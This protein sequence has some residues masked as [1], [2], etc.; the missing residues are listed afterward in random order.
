[1]KKLFI[2]I[3]ALLA[4]GGCASKYAVTFDSY[5][6][7]A[8]LLCNGTNWGYTPVTLYYDKA[9]KKQ[10]SLSLGSCSANWTSGA[11]K[12]YGVVPVSQYPD[13]VRQTLQRPNEPNAHIDHSFALQ[14]QQNK[15][16]N[17][18]LQ[19]QSAMQAEQQRVKNE[20]QQED[21]TQ[22]LCNLGLLTY[23]CK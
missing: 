17:Q 7:G 20:K 19:N 3:A 23:G 1:M 22:Y 11:R 18:V 21:N 2:C 13:G 5:P 8:T 10:S 16:M 15:Q 9:V 4:L 14:V 6:Q 12:T